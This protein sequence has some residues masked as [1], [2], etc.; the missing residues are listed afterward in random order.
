M[1]TA[2]Q[3]DF[4]VGSVPVY[5][6]AILAPMH[7]YS[8]QPFRSLARRLGSAMS[9]SQFVS[10]KSVLT[11]APDVAQRLAYAEWERPI[12]FQLYGD[13]PHQLLRAAL[14]MQQ[15]E[16]DVIDIN[17]GCPTRA[18]TGRGAGAALLGQP[19][20]IAR[21]FR[22]LGAALEVPLSAKMRLGLDSEQRNTLQ[23]ARAIADN[24]GALVTVHG[25]TQSQGYDSRADWDAIAEVKAAL[26][27]PVIGN[28]DV[29]TAADIHK[30]LAHTS[31]EAVMVGRAAIGNP[32]LFAGLERHQVSPQQVRQ[33]MLQHLKDMQRFYG[34][35]DGL[36]LFRKHAKRY[37]SPYP[38][39]PEE[40]R[41]L[42]T[43]ET[44]EHFSHL[45]HQVMALKSV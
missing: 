24:G 2:I 36:K 14:V 34:P 15:L 27:I 32:W 19:E 1:G 8:D 18:V 4:R 22:T 30:M 43:C 35:Q 9:F 12:A 29:R 31:C 44:A 20:K 28:G 7:G 3:P 41:A 11:G 38:L 13:D 40:R 37:L 5:G 6:R 25:R 21:I 17:L 33:L 45:L 26:D 42:L 39:A 16:P 10:A 23:V